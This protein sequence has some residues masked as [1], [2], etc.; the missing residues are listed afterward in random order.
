MSGEEGRDLRAERL[1]ALGLPADLF[2][3][4]PGVEGAG[5]SAQP[6]TMRLELGSNSGV[7]ATITRVMVP[8]PMTRSAA[9]G[10]AG[11]ATPGS[12]HTV[13]QATAPGNSARN[14][15]SSRST[16]S[17]ST[18]SAETSA[19]PR[20]SAPMPFFFRLL[21]DQIMRSMVA[22]ASAREPRTRPAKPSLLD[23]LPTARV[24][25]KLAED[26]CPVCQERFARRGP[27]VKRLPCGHH[28][29]TEC[30]QPWLRTHNTCPN[31]RYELDT[32]DD[33]YNHKLRES[34]AKA[35]VKREQRLDLE[36]AS[37]SFA[38]WPVTELKKL[39]VGRGVDFS[40]VVEKIDLVK[41]VQTSTPAEPES[42]GSV[43]ENGSRAA[44]H[45]TGSAAARDPP[46]ADRRP[47]IGLPRSLRRL[48]RREERSPMP[49]WTRR[50]RRR[51][52]REAAAANAPDLDA[53]SAANP[54]R[55]RSSL[56]DS[57][58]NGD[59]GPHSP[60][61]VSFNFFDGT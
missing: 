15:P 46:H 54:Q 61:S 42:P 44:R 33:R 53:R 55:S 59:G 30:L 29:H 48:Q 57:P 36:A 21:I 40:D 38:T 1:L 19:S 56:P 45:G 28:F 9:R 35:I 49:L 26:D 31:C 20:A 3:G 2:Q 8:V 37:S 10:T 18:S 17:S 52:S 22:G 41:L 11:T 34:R 14:R 47:V 50:N 51:A 16:G 43:A 60:V 6:V 25:D 4:L 5:P 32:A 12:A 23:S 39:L 24:C 58:F 7:T 13:D 27:A